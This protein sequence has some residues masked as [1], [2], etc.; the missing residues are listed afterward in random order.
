MSRTR[1]TLSRHYRL[2]L[3]GIL[4]CYNP[5]TVVV[6]VLNPVTVKVFRRL[7]EHKVWN[8]T[9]QWNTRSASESVTRLEMTSKLQRGCQMKQR[10]IAKL[11]KAAITN[12]QFAIMNTLR[13]SAAAQDLLCKEFSLHQF[14]A[15][16]SRNH[17]PLLPIV[18]AR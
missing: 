15:R 2:F 8:T 6:K 14:S 9:Q 4:R 3:D 7:V 13:S 1:R 5:E 18:L 11:K 12:V 17:E 16:M 10:N